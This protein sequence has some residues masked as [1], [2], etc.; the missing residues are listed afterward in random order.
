VDE[1]AL[2]LLESQK[3]N[4]EFTTAW[5]WVLLPLLACT[6]A[7]WRAA[8]PVA[9][10]GT[11][12]RRWFIPAPV[13]SRLQLVENIL[14]AAVVALFLWKIWPW[15]GWGR[16]IRVGCVL[17][18]L[19]VTIRPLLKTSQLPWAGDWSWSGWLYHAFN[20]LFSLFLLGLVL[21]SL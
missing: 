17:L 7:G 5:G 14:E 21:F 10:S 16:L 6:L 13:S 2:H 15:P 12:K 11:V 9:P 20:I 1:L 4:L 18:L 3:F 8:Q 19:L